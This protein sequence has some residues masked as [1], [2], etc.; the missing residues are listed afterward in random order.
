M[1]K[2]AFKLE[3]LFGSKTRARL[4]ALFLQYPD[5]A[6]FVR[7]ITRK[8][9]AQL[10]SVRRELKNLID[11]GLIVEKTGKGLTKKGVPLSEKKK[12][13]QAE[14]SSLLFE[15]LRSLFQKIQILL[16]NNFVQ[17]IDSKGV[18]SY[19]AFTGR[20]VDRTDVPT[21]IILVGDIKQRPLEN[22]IAEFEKEMGHEVNFTLMPREEFLYRRQVADRF[23]SSIIESDKIV[24]IDRL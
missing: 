22:L 20:F 13:Y 3:Q 6:F 18:I 21:D 2:Q 5:Q 1:A 19:F 16:K 8:I 10:N 4:I 14:E 15:D 23:L 7:E 12:Y 11:L 24:M 17:E 9:D